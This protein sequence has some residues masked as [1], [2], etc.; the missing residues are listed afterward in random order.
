MKRYH[1]TEE[2]RKEQY[3]EDKYRGRVDGGCLRCIHWEGRPGDECSACSRA[4]DTS[5]LDETRRYPM[6]EIA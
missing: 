1:M 4:S 2:E 5:T 3:Y 6:R